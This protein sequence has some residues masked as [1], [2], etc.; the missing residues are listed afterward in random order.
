MEKKKTEFIQLR[1]VDGL[2]LSTIMGKLEI[3]KEIA[4]KWD[5]ELSDEIEETIFDSF[6]KIR[7]KFGLVTVRRFH[8]LAAIYRRLQD[9]INK[10]DFSGLPTDTLYYMMEDVADKLDLFDDFLDDTEE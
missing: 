9:E 4:E 2:A 8:D 10:R 7:E 3:S 5:M 6:E 1:A